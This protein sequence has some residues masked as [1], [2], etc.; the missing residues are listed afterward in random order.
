MVRLLVPRR[1]LSRRQLVLLAS[2]AALFGGLRYG[3]RRVS[4]SADPSGPLS[5]GAKGLITRAWAGL[6]PAKVLDVH[7]HVLGTGAGGTGCFVGPRMS[8]LSSPIEYLKFSIYEQASGVTDSDQCDVQYLDRLIGLMKTQRPHGRALLLAFDQFHDADG[9][10]VKEDT[11]FFTPNQYVLQLAARHPEL[12][13]PCASV[14]PYRADAVEALTAA[15]EAGA[16]AVK[17]LPNAMNIDP[18]SP[19]CDAFYAAMK[20]L[21]VPL[22]SHAGEEKAVHA[23]ERQRLGNPLHLRRPLEHGVKVVV[24]HCACLGQNPDLDAPEASRPWVDNFELFTRLMDEPK[25]AGLLFG[26]ISAMTI[27]NRIGKPLQRVLRDPKLQA[28]LMNGSDYPLPALN[29]L[30]QTRAV[31]QQGF[32]T[33]EERGWLNE[34]DQHDPLLFDFVMKRTLRLRENGQEHRLADALFTFPPDVFARLT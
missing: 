27:V 34:I 33:A 2:G 23:E 26:E 29:V 9:K 13:V 19:R 30:M 6:D 15:V 20:A 16:V 18:S 8:S 10:A 24:A 17:W 3:H 1:F 14:H 7:V 32:I 31:E 5:D 22:L 25:W 11:E 21:R 4:R 12:F 28:R